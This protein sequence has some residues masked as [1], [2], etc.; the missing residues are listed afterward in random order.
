[1]NEP[2]SNALLKTLEEPSGDLLLIL[3]T[4]KRDALLATIRSRCQQIR[5]DMLHVDVL[6]EGLVR[7]FH[8]PA[9]KAAQAALLANGNVIEALDLASGGLLIPRAELREYLLD[10]YKGTPL[11]LMKRIKTYTDIEDK[12][13]LTV[14]LT[15]LAGWF[16]DVLA[17]HEGSP[18]LIRNTDLRVPIQ[19]FAER[20]PDA[21]CAE[22]IEA[23]ETTIEM[24][25]KNVHLVTALIVLSHRLRHCIAPGA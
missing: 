23:I 18:E 14:F 7:L 25:Q 16:R 19:Q 6:Q 3:T 15:G 13:V 10:V 17:V 12:K 21:R 9:E 22:A 5:F 2:A 8:I 20:F 11:Q 24:I 4:A 1:M